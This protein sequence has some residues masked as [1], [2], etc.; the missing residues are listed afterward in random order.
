[1]QF[2]RI[3]HLQAELDM[4]LAAIRRCRM[5]YPREAGLV[6]ALRRA[7]VFGLRWR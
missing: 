4:V 6:H 1:M 3:A 2:T 7:P 5:A